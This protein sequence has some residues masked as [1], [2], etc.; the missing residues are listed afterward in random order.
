MP[1]PV[2]CTTVCVQ[3]FLN[4]LRCKSTLAQSTGS[5]ELRTQ[6]TIVDGEKK[7]LTVITPRCPDNRRELRVH[8]TTVVIVVVIT[9]SSVH[10]TISCVVFENIVITTVCTVFVDLFPPPRLSSLQETSCL[11]A[12]WKTIMKQ[13]CLG[14]KKLYAVYT[15][16]SMLTLE[17][18]G[19]LYILKLVCY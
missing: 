11:S 13:V 10:G 15:K 7:Y 8:A 2:T 5:R 18:M 14:W 1:V 3:I 4:T 17:R 19:L 16:T 6:R 9:Y 12:G